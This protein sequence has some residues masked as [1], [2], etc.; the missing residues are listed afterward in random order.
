MRIKVMKLTGDDV[1]SESGG[2]LPDRNVTFEFARR[3]LKNLDFVVASANAGVHPVTQAVTSLLAIVIFPWERSAFNRVKNKRLSVLV[4]EGWPEWSMSGSRA[5]NNG[6]KSLG[7]LIKL[8]RNSAAHG[9]VSFDSDSRNPR[10]VHV[11][12]ENFPK[13]KNI[14]SNWRGSIRADQLIE[15]C[16][17]FSRRIEEEAS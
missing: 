6:V 13:G 17:C 14:P 4:Q 1:G 16:R 7:A 3:S 9:N 10:L 2:M 11:E 5:Q 8:L 12:F 15:F